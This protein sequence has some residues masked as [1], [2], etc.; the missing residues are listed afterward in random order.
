MPAIKRIRIKKSGTWLQEGLIVE[1]NEKEAQ[2]AST[3]GLSPERVEKA[4]AM[5]VVRPTIVI[6]V[7]NQKEGD[8]LKKLIQENIPPQ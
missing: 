6:Q 2:V 1:L 7:D 8:R 4:G 5:G 3:L